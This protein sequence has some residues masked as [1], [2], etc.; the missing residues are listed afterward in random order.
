MWL[1]H[2]HLPSSSKPDAFPSADR[3]ISAGVSVLQSVRISEHPGGE[4]CDGLRQRPKQDPLYPGRQLGHQTKRCFDLEV[5]NT[6][7]KE[8]HP[9]SNLKT[10]VRWRSWNR[11]LDNEVKRR[12]TS[13]GLHPALT[14]G[15]DDALLLCPSILRHCY[16]FSEG[17]KEDG[18]AG[19]LTS[20]LI[21]HR[22]PITAENGGFLAN[23]VRAW[24][25]SRL[26]VKVGWLCKRIS[27]Q[28]LQNYF[29]TI[30]YPYF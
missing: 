23:P 22:Q 20:R 14:R 26:A 11:V 24:I 28:L 6:D 8:I 2:L 29:H 10:A 5:G 27:T 7:A 19:S 17:G 13:V 1:G 30:P 15:P 3:V 18:F 21:G 25:S 4:N 9:K 16:F 12:P